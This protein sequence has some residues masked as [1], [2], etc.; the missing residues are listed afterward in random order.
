[1]NQPSPEIVDLNTLPAV[2][3]PCGTARRAFKDQG[4]FPGTVH[5]TE[6]KTDARPHF[7]K[8]L[9][10]IYVILD[11]EP[12]ASMELDGICHP[13]QPMSAIM[14]PPGV[15]HRAVG[16]HS[17]SV[18]LFHS[19]VLEC[20]QASMQLTGRIGAAQA[21]TELLKQVTSL[22]TGIQKEA[23]VAIS[24]GFETTSVDHA[25]RL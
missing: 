15:I 12:D 13:V 21:S 23:R 18:A 14:I 11:C 22:T 24:C 16:T 19:V 1:M 17:H 25:H 6:I 20:Y 7:H 9:T 10:E 2:D 4:S 5:L 3:C 8:N